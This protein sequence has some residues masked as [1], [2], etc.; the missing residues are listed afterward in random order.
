MTVPDSES[1]WAIDHW[2]HVGQRT[3]QVLRD[4]GY[5]T[6]AEVAALTV[7]ELRFLPNVGP[8]TVGTIVTALAARGL[9][10]R[11]PQGMPCPHCKGTGF[12]ETVAEVKL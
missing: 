12:I 11:A 8:A 5:E 10:L 3:R 4:A 9:S 2:S 6:I 7:Q 1:A